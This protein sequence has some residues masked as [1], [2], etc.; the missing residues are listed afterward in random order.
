MCLC[1]HFVNVYI[2]WFS[3]IHAMFVCVCLHMCAV[4]QND[5]WMQCE[6]SRVDFK[7]PNSVDLL[8]TDR[9]LY[10]SIHLHVWA[11]THEKSFTV[12]ACVFRCKKVQVNLSH[13]KYHFMC[14]IFTRHT[15]FLYISHVKYYMNH[16]T[17]DFCVRMAWMSPMYLAIFWWKYENLEHTVVWRVTTLS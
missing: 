11:H 7:D 1:V 12:C 6:P 17:Y 8:H 9:E 2:R 13:M 3:P 5:S 4:I 14:N 16:C 15:L 10:R